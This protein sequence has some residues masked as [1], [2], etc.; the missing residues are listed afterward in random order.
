M[1]ILKPNQKLPGLE[2]TRERAVKGETTVEVEY[3]MTSLKPEVANAERLAGQV[4]THWG[5]RTS[6]TTCVT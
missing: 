2:I 1:T 4:R 6:Y 3:A 5:S